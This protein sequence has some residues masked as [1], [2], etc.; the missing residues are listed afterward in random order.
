MSDNFTASSM[1]SEEEI[2]F[3]DAVREFAEG[4]VRPLVHEMDTK[5]Q[6]DPTIIE[7]C[8]DMGLMGIEVPEELGGQG[9]SFF[10][11]VLAVEEL[12]RV[13][14]AVAVMVD[15][16]TTLFENMVPRRSRSWSTSRPRCSRTWS[17]AGAA[18]RS[19]S[20]SCPR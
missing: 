17:S 15:V 13:D 4:T 18:T 3:R 9:G 7:A 2:A 19:S 12:A 6:M 11:A 5:Q 20:G 10:Q 16:Q 8:F 14:P 1:L